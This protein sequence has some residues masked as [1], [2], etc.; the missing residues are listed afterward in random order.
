MDFTPKMTFNAFAERKKRPN[1]NFFW[2]NFVR[3]P[4]QSRFLCVLWR[5]ETFDTFSCLVSRD[6]FPVKEETR[7]VNIL[8]IYNNINILKLLQCLWLQH[9]IENSKFVANL[10]L[11]SY[12]IEWFF[13]WTKM[14]SEFFTFP[15][16]HLK[17]CKPKRH[18]CSFFYQLLCLF[19]VWFRVGFQNINKPNGNA[20]W[21]AISQ[22]MAFRTIVCIECRFWAYNFIWTCMPI[23]IIS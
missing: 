2:F 22:I 7:H 13:G 4:F 21:A 18:A 12:R 1:K 6:R 9:R 5:S 3:S 19:C 10:R 16:W 17:N 20:N 15:I 14:R 11:L 8:I 23:A